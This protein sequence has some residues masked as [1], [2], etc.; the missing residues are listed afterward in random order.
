MSSEQAHLID[1]AYYRTIS[2]STFHFFPFLSLSSFWFRPFFTDFDLPLTAPALFPRHA[3]GVVDRP[4]LLYS[5][6]EEAMGCVVST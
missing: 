1:F 2:P 4:P 3:G 6:L 5:E